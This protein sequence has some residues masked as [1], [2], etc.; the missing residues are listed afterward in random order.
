MKTV[1]I[2]GA[3]GVGKTTLIK[4]LK[5]SL[6][7]KKIYDFDSV[8]VP[9]NPPLSWR[10]KTTKHWLA[11]AEKNEKVGKDTLIVGLSFPFEILSFSKKRDFFFCLLDINIK[12]RERRL[13]KRES[14]KD[15]INDTEQVIKLK[16]E[17]KKLKNKKII[18]AS[19]LSPIQI[20]KKIIN[21]LNS[22]R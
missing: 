22:L 18:N 20:S 13:K 16:K 2:T 15:V 7:N 12:E 4:I 19:N 14:P 8:G 6:A 1:F 21:W 9:K 5:K 3:E 11:V 10:H 17:F